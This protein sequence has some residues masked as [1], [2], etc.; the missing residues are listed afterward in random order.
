MAVLP[1]CLCATGENSSGKSVAARFV[2]SGDLFQQRAWDLAP[3]ACTVTPRS[4]FVRRI[5]YDAANAYMLIDLKGMVYHYRGSK[6][7]TAVTP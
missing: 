6:H 4:S 1:N 7:V 2:G 5:C 3:F